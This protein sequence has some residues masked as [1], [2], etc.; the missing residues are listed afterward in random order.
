MMQ[1]MSLLFPVFLYGS[2]S[3][4]NLYILTSTTIGI[5]EAKRIRDHIKEREEAEKSGKV[6]VDPKDKKGG[7]GG[8]L[9]RKFT[10]LQERVEE[11]R[12]RGEQQGKNKA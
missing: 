6:L 12:R 4:L 9:G 2:P 8:F 10:E 3:G 7:P 1:W 5:I 11:I